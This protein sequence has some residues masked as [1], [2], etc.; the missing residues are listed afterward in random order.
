MFQGDKESNNHSSFTPRTEGS[1]TCRK[2]RTRFTV[3]LGKNRDCYRRM[4]CPACGT[5]N[6]FIVRRNGK[7]HGPGQLR[8]A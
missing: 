1:I 4:S 5:T 2:C 3:L 7:V 6:T 8:F